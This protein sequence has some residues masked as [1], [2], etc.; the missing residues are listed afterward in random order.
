MQWASREAGYTEF[1]V[2]DAFEVFFAARNEVVFFEEVVPVLERLANRYTLGALSN[3]NADI[4]M[5]GLGEL[6]SFSLNAV[7][8]GAAKPAPNMFIEACRYL[9]LAPAQIVH[10]GDDPEHDVL[11]AARVGLRHGLGETATTGI[12]PGGGERMP[13]LARWRSWKSCW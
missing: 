10:V 3:G 8:A 6:F 13:R 7:T 4:D 11:G 2:E 1:R 5:I 12:G 9:S